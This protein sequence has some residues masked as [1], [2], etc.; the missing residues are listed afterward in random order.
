[1]VAY[2]LLLVSFPSQMTSW[3]PPQGV[4]QQQPDLTRAAAPDPPRQQVTSGL[5]RITAERGW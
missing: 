4:S 2:V 5:M 3:M 1:M